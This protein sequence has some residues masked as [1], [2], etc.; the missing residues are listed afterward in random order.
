VLD[1]FCIY[2]CNPKSTPNLR[3]ALAHTYERRRSQY[4]SSRSEKKYID[5]VISR[6]SFRACLIEKTQKDK[7]KIDCERTLQEVKSLIPVYEPVEL[8]LQYFVVFLKQNHNSSTC[9]QS[10]HKRTECV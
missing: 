4:V 9:L 3:L 7:T 10:H 1:D 8:S 5:N 6:K 2:L